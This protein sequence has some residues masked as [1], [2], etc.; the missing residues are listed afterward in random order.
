MSEFKE[1][2]HKQLVSAIIKFLITLII[3]YFVKFIY[4]HYFKSDTITFDSFFELI[5]FIASALVDVVFYISVLILQNIVKLIKDKN[6]KV[7]VRFRT[8]IGI[9]ALIIN[10]KQEILLINDRDEKN[11]FYKQPGTRYRI[12]DFGNKLNDTIKP[13]DKIL[14]TIEIETGLT[15]N[16]LSLLNFIKSN[17]DWDLRT[18]TRES[19]SGK[20]ININYQKNELIPPPFLIES[21]LGNNPKHDISTIDLFYA[22]EIK[23]YAEKKIKKS[24]KLKFFNEHGIDTL[25]LNDLNNNNQVTTIHHDIGVIIKEFYSLLKKNKPEF[26]YF[27]CFYENIIEDFTNVKKIYG[28]NYM[29]NQSNNC[30]NCIN[31]QKKICSYSKIDKAIAYEEEIKFSYNDIVPNDTILISGINSYVTL[32]KALNELV[33]YDNKRIILETTGL[34]SENE[35]HNIDEWEFFKQDMKIDCIYIMSDYRFS[36]KVTYEQ[37]S[38][39]SLFVDKIGK[40]TKKIIYVTNSEMI[41]KHPVYII[42]MCMNLKIKDLNI[43]YKNDE[44]AISNLFSILNN[45]EKSVSKY[46][47]YSYL[48]SISFVSSKCTENKCPSNF[49]DSCP[50][51]CEILKN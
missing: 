32:K 30:I 13:I 6:L 47:K 22:F 17:Y 1:D 43:L 14:K 16:D 38:N 8:T 46:K 20:H 7:F 39:L 10:K 50:L 4:F 44:N 37:D 36:T 35:D 48:N 5:D 15:P 28:Y 3:W 24:N 45:I 41:L 33:K 9:S 34:F 18:K 40:Y 42:K 49:K 11:P 31:S 23:E 25:I 2:L 21:Q 19:L 51:K 29:E 27:N 12:K 26:N